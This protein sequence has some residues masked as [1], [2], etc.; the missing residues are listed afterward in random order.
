MEGMGECPSMKPAFVVFAAFF[1]ITACASS[2]LAADEP[3][4]IRSGV[5]GF[6]FCPESAKD[7]PV[8]LYVG[9]CK[10]RQI[11]TLNCGEKVEVL[12][13]QD[14]MLRISTGETGPRGQRRTDLVAASAISR[15]PDKFVPFDDQSGV[16]AR[17]PDC[18][19]MLARENAPGGF[20]FCSSGKDSA[21]VYF[22]ACQSHAAGSLACGENVRVLSRHG[23]ML[24]VTTPPHDLPRYMEASAVSQQADKFAPFDDNSGVQDQG[25]ADCSRAGSSFGAGAGGGI[26]QGH[27]PER[28]VTMPRAIFMP[29]PEFTDL[30]RKKKIQGVVTLSLIVGIDGTT[31]DITV[32]KG[33][34]YGLDE[35]AVQ[36]VSRWKFTP[37]LKDGEPIEQKIAVEVSFRL[38]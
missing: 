22:S 5:E 16:P 37:A 28:N 8:P 23:D 11:G 19:G 13:R 18:S 38:Y 24:Q 7:Q 4:V 2:P 35:K 20:V 31:H 30:A 12:N 3:A 6:V 25:A 36:A 27:P 21:P 26:S 1:V 15:Q 34:G 14:D 17:S 10:K 9:F 29:D 32:D 33:I